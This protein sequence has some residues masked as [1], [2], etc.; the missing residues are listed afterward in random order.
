MATGPQAQ[1]AADQYADD[2]STYPNV[3]GI[4]TRP[5]GD[6]RSAT[7]SGTHAVAV[8]VSRKVP[9]DQLAAHER[10]PDYVEVRERDRTTQVPVV[11]V[12]TGDIEPEGGGDS[13]WDRGFTS[14]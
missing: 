14:D 10:L 5:L 2:L 6:Q 12:E 1:R 13:G 11:V 7:D 4:G 8:Y 3:V 9:A